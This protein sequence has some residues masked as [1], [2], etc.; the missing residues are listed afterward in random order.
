MVGERSQDVVKR[1]VGSKGVGAPRRAYKG[2]I[3]VQL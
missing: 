1:W 3:L 2:G